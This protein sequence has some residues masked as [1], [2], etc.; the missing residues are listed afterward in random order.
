[1]KRSVVIF[2]TILFFCPFSLSAQKK[3][4]T[5]QEVSTTFKSSTFSGIQWRSIGP[6]VASGRIA[7]FAVN[8]D[9][10]KEYYVAVASG[11]VWKTEN[12]GITYEPVFDNKGAYSMGVVTMDPTNHNCIWIGTGENNH[13]RALGY[14]NGVWKSMDGGKSWTNMG[15]KESRQIGDIVINPENHDI[16]YV[17]AEG[18]VWGPGG[19]RGLYKTTDGGKTWTKVLE[20]SEHTG[21][22]NIVMDARDPDVLY[23]SSEQRRRHVFTKIGGGPETAIYKSTDGGQNWK[24]LTSG[25]PKADMGGMG[26]AI[27]PVNPDIIYAII[28]AAEDNGGFYRSTNRGESW[29]KMSSYSSSGQY[30]NEIFCDPTD[31]D[32]IYSM[33][34]YTKVTRD[35]GKTWSNLGNNNRHVDDHAMWIDPTDPEHFLI[36]GDGGIYESLDGGKNYHFKANL[37]VTQFYRVNVDNDNPFYNVYGGTQDNNTIGGPSMN[38]S[39][40][41]V[42]ND[43]WYFTLGGDGFWAAIEPGNPDIVYCESQYGNISRY[44]RKSGEVIDIQPQPRKEEDTYKWNW[45]TPLITSPHSSTRLY[46]AANKVFRSDDRGN[47][48][49]VISEDITAKID[50]NT[51][52]VMDHYWSYDAVAKDVSTSQFGTAVSLAESPVK[53]DLIYVGTDDGVISITENAGKEWRQVKSFPG[54]PA[55]TYVSDILP[56]KYNENTVYASFDNHKRDDFTPYIL[57]STDKGRTWVSI[58]GN[59]P[60]N[61][62]VHTIEQDFINPNL[63]FIGTE[64]T[65]Y[66]S[67][68][69]GKEWIQLNSGLPSIAVKDMIIQKREQDLVI[70]TFGRG[71]YILDDYSPLREVTKELIDQ[72]AHIFPVKDALMYIQTSGKGNQGSTYFAAKNP[73]FGATFTYYF[74]DSL[75]TLKE[76]RHEKEKKLFDAKM[77]IPQP[78]V[79]ELRAEENE[80][81]PYLLFTIFDE[82]GNEV[83]KLTAKP[84]K[85]I[86][87]ISWDLKYTS[88]NPVRI[89]GQ[90]FNPLAE[91]QSYM[92]AMPG[93]Y[94]ISL[95]KSLNGEITQLVPPVPFNALVLENTTLPVSDR[96]ELVEF[97]QK[98]GELSRI[99]RATERFAGELYNRTQYIQQ[100]L[101]QTPGNTAYLLKQTRD[102]EQKILDIQFQFEGRQPRASWEEIPPAPMPLN[103]RLN[104][105][106]STHWRSTSGITQTQKDNYAILTEEF[107]PLLEQLK[108]INE[109]LGA[110]EKNLDNLKVP[111]TPGRIP[112]WE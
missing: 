7:D 3:K 21:V 18:S 20:I 69:G 37:P 48:W 19:D 15:L 32:V 6:A 22:N 104:T 102:M 101:L 109:E 8:P 42:V 105:I 38:T 33:D 14:G 40:Q 96:Q 55:N 95:S 67:F 46:C 43:E 24:K 93:Q 71:F 57:K 53:E 60:K 11:H 92:F 82:D 2:L 74:N 35:G 84:G 81:P 111:W 83:R 66:C 44:D 23:A 91:S 5:E 98:T 54:V 39:R 85:G 62:M 52:P 16:V 72:P 58:S 97:Q 88:P 26:I 78:S 77:P 25:L 17:A 51:W 9:N 75:K 100:T 76:I 94:S 89:S 10:T 56:D 45:N 87:R 65:V 30:Y 34:T 59:L 80:E 12:A 41:G 49:Q 99:M 1:M 64:F 70:A 47:T 79:E 73:D 110:L 86:K 31:A 13:Q 106:I 107:P 28:E 112:V 63:L 36:G 27:S 90:E 68:D 61:G 4:V 29:A 108:K 103:R 50:R